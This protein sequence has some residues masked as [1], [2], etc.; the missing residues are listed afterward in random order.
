[1]QPTYQMLAQQ[2]LKEKEL[3]PNNGKKTDPAHPAIYP[4]GQF[5][6]N[7]KPKEQRLYDLIVK[8][9]MATFA[10]PAV[11][12]TMTAQ[13]DVKGEEFIA[14]GTRTLQENWHVFYKPYLK[15]E[16][17]TM[18]AMKKGEPV[19]ID[20][21]EKHDEE[22]QPPARYNQSSIIKELEKRNLGTKATRAEI[23]DTLFR[24]GYAQGVKITVT[25]L[26]METERILEKYAPTIVDE[27]LTA[28]FE[29]DMEKIREGKEKPE[30]VLDKA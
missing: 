20:K 15:M 12:E 29:G 24:R 16:E 30:T 2:L 5:P 23:L 14:K 19:A 10:Q 22:T 28:D 13:F 18:P 21:I 25:K 27:N 26:G 6:G 1:K 8:R 9:F 7:L 4:T 17:V 11:R 3:K